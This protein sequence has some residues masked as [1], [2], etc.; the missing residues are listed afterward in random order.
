MMI[1]SFFFSLSLS[2]LV[3]ENLQIHFIFKYLISRF[4]SVFWFLISKGTFNLDFYLFI[5][6][7]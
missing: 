1:F 7:F 6:L 3:I 4:I 5:Y 2:L